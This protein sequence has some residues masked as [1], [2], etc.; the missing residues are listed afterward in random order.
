MSQGMVRRAERVEHLDIERIVGGRG[1]RAVEGEIGLAG[2][3]AE[4]QQPLEL[5]ERFL[6]RGLL[7]AV[8]AE[9]R[10]SGALDLD[11]PCAPRAR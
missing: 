3:L 7:R 11:R 9:R 4:R 6:D 10:K 2:R 1:D 5:E 8:A